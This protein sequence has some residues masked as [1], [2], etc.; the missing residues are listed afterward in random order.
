MRLA[1]REER[2]GRCVFT[3]EQGGQVWPE[4]DAGSAGEGGEIENQAGLGGSGFR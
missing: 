1:R 3:R 4:R 2:G